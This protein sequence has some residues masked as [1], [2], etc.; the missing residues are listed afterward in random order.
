MSK[1]TGNNSKWIAG[2]NSWDS[3]NILRAINYWRTGQNI[4]AEIMMIELSGKAKISAPEMKP[5][6]AKINRQGR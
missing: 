4:R 2:K 6:P 3:G 1:R 5:G